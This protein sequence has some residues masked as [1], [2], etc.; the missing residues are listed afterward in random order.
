MTPS[1]TSMRSRLDRLWMRITEPSPALADPIAQYDARLLTAALLAFGALYWL[2]SL[3]RLA[4]QTLAPLYISALLASTVSL[5]G[6]YAL[7]RTRHFRLTVLLADVYVGVIVF[8]MLA[9]DVR[10]AL[11]NN[12]L[13]YFMLAVVLTGLL[14]SVRATA[15]VAAGAVALTALVTLVFAPPD[16][17]L[18]AGSMLQMNTI[19]AGLSVTLAVVQRHNRRVIARHIQDLAE[20]EASQLALFAALSDPVIVH[21]Q[22]I[23]ARVNPAFETVFGY[24]EA[25]VVGQPAILYAAPESRALIAEKAQSLQVERYEALALH[26]DGSTFPIE[27]SS[28]PYTHQGNW[29]RVSVIRDISERKEA[30]RALVEERNLLQT[31]INT[32]PDQVY[33]KD[34]ESRFILI[35]Q[36]LL[37]RYGLTHPDEI[38][39]KTDFDLF[40]PEIAQRFYDGE[41]ALLAS[42]AGTTTTYD[43][44]ETLPDLSP[45]WVQ[46]T[47]VPLLDSSGRIAGVLGINRDITDYR[48]AEQQRLDLALERQRVEIL[49]RFIAG[50]SHDLNTP[51]AALKT[52]LYLLRRTIDDPDQRNRRMDGF[53]EQVDRLAAMVA[54]LLDLDRLEREI[55]PIDRAP[56]PLET[57]LAPVIAEAQTLTTQRGQ[58][59]TAAIEPGLPP[60]VVNAEMMR[61]AL[62]NLLTN[63]ALYT[64]ARGTITLAAHRAG[65]HIDIAVRDN[66]IGIE[67]ADLTRIFEGFYRADKA[68]SSG[69]GRSGLGLA[70]ARRIALAHG[71]DITV[72]SEPGAGSTFT[73]Q[74]PVMPDT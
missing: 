52:G 62:D 59:F 15:I 37:H 21:R 10:L 43:S 44:R 67:P 45:L 2:T 39:G 36:A 40:G 71:G 58:S 60:L 5:F 24:A 42:G 57:L 65:A 30:E 53:E 9:S 27:I 29:M 46:V 23:I 66:G 55:K 61:Q 48:R 11:E 72:V 18:Q 34:T 47:K 1:H 25:E 41:R 26:R 69:T 49:R 68:R 28:R 20:R 14:L 31:V 70:I 63:A 33:V 4:L 51:L 8:A 73:L 7:S 50:L 56:V 38:M 54:E 16:Q 22:G 3:A 19:I 6:L 17:E 12:T 32:I 35:N 13:T 74:L 64:P